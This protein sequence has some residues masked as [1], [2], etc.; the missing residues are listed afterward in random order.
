M[1]ANPALHALVSKDE[2]LAAFRQRM[3]WRFKW[4]SSF[5]SDFN[6]D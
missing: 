3:G 5:G 2:W 4:V 6:H 1:N